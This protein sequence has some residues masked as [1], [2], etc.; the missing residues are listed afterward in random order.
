VDVATQAPTRTEA[1]TPIHNET[2]DRKGNPREVNG[3]LA[4]D[5]AMD[6]NRQV[7]PQIAVGGGF[8]LRGTNLGLIIYDKSGNYVNGVRQSGFNGGIDPKMF[9]DP[10]N[11]VFGFDLWNPWD[12]ASKLSAFHIMVGVCHRVGRL[13]KMIDLLEELEK[14]ATEGYRIER[15]RTVLKRARELA[16]SNGGR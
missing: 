8:V 13:Q 15:A 9:F 2:F 1:I 4:F 6:G 12:R 10:H 14:S 5:G 7:D 16:S 3:F 11:R